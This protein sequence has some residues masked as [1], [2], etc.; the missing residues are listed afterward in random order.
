MTASRN[1][2]A[3]ASTPSILAWNARS[4][5]LAVVVWT[6]LAMYSVTGNIVRARYVGRPI[7]V[8]DLVGYQ[9]INW[10]SCAIF[11]PL[12]IWMARRWPIERASW[13]ARVPLWLGVTLLIVPL[14]FIIEDLAIRA[15]GLEV[16]RDSLLSAIVFGFVPETIAFFSMI[17]VVLSLAYYE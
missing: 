17:A 11:T 10:Y 12:Y 1:H 16:R 3:M 14:K 2:A 13:R 4:V 9:L 5:I 15:V 7:D 8:S 6:G